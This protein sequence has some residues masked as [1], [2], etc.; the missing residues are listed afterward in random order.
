MVQNSGEFRPAKARACLSTVMRAKAGIRYTA[1]SRPLHVRLWNTGSSAF[2]VP[3]LNTSR[4]MTA[5]GEPV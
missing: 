5:K 3:G 1:A 4:T 2:Y